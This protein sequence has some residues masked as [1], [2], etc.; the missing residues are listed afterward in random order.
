ME[1]YEKLRNLR[2]EHRMSQEEFANQLNVSRQ[3]VS[4]WESGQGFPETDKLL[5]ISNIFGVSLDYLLKSGADD[6]DADSDGSYYVN[7]EMAQGYLA[8]KRYGAV[9]IALGVAV[10]ILSVSLTMLFDNATGT[11]LFFFGIAAGVAILVLQDFRP[12]RYE[13]VENKPLVFDG[14]FLREF[15]AQC[16]AE[17][18]KYGFGIVAGIAVLIASYAANVLIE[19]ILK[20]PPQYEAIYP[21]FWAVGVAILI[22]NGSAMSSQDVLAKNDEHIKELEGNK[23]SS[24]IYGTGFLIAA[25]IFLF[26]GIVFDLWRPSWIVFPV[27]GLVCTAIKLG[28]DAK[29]K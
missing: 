20:L 27:T 5:L 24:W 6:K 23:R 11:F 1:F 17:R 13:E 18:K 15:K 9:R 25:A 7:R 12:N 10:I 19:E 3:A 22:I 29:T 14:D 21:I 8:A 4:K 26:I 2:K 28:L 16:A